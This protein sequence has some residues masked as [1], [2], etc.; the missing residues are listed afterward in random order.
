MWQQADMKLQSG[1][2]GMLG[3]PEAMY[4]YW[5][6]LEQNN[7]PNASSMRKMFEQKVQEQKMM[8]QMALPTEPGT[9]PNMNSALI[10]DDYVQDE[11]EKSFTENPME[12]GVTAD[13]YLSQSLVGELG[14]M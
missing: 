4:R 12:E 13:P 14:G 5:T 10:P 8:A 7:Y 11:T 9:A 1:A 2:F 6:F 3:E